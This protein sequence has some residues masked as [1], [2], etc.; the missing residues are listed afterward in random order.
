[1]KITNNLA[2]T[3]KK[4]LGKDWRQKVRNLD[5]RGADFR[6]ADFSGANFRRANFSGANFRYANFRRANFSGADFRRANF[7]GADF[8]GANFRGANFRYANFSGADFSGADFRRANF[9]GANFSGADFS[10]AD[11]YNYEK[12]HL[13]ALANACIY[14]LDVTLK[15][16]I[17]AKKK[18]EAWKQNKTPLPRKCDDY[19]A[20]ENGW[21]KAFGSEDYVITDNELHAF[22]FFCWRANND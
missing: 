10:G 21:K 3:L 4:C 16:L 2:R 15:V 22:W 17:E 13:I 1:M 18:T 11:F 20:C 7:S 9:S 12:I 14:P 5:F 6:R 8:S 19:N